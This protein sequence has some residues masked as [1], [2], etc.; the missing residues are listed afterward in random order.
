M[1]AWD[2]GI[3]QSDADMNIADEIS[4]DVGKFANVADISLLAPEDEEA[5]VATLNNGH[6]TTLRERYHAKKQYH[7][8]F[9]L[10]GLAMRFGANISAD[11]TNTL[12]K[13]TN[14]I[15]NH[16]KAKSQMLKAVKDYKS[17]EAYDFKSPGVEQTMTEGAATGGDPC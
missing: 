11:Q 7:N 1:G 3:F 15:T 6:C 2:Y 12:E 9:F 10:C 16:D 13:L 17:G 5:T 4:D 14:E 8:I